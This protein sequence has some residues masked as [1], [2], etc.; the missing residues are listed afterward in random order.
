MQALGKTTER[1]QLVGLKLAAAKRISLME[2][3][4][5]AVFPWINLGERR[6]KGIQTIE[7]LGLVKGI[8]TAL[9]HH[10]GKIAVECRHTYILLIVL[11]SPRAQNAQDEPADEQ[12]EQDGNHRTGQTDSGFGSNRN[13][14][15]HRHILAM[16][17]LAPTSDRAHIERPIVGAAA[18]RLAHVDNLIGIERLAIVP[19][20]DLYGR[21]SLPVKVDLGP[22]VRIGDRLV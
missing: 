19:R 20:S 9:L 18:P 13:A 16:L 7:W 17:I 21:P 3:N 15:R 5:S 2:P 6:S 1:A 10:K 11:D 14:V 8:H 12:S 4:R 22:R